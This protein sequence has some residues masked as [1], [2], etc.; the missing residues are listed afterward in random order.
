MRTNMPNLISPY[1]LE[2]GIPKKYRV[3]LLVY[4][5]SI[6]RAMTRKIKVH[7]PITALLKF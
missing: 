3:D 1:Y 7:T 4:P 2:E 5:R 6:T